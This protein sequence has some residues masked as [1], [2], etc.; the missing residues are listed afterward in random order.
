M[1]IKTDGQ[2]YQEV[3][4]LLEQHGGI[5]YDN[6]CNVQRVKVDDVCEFIDRNEKCGMS[7][8]MILHCLAL[9]FIKRNELER[10]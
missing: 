4:D 10:S 2:I 8:D 7:S 3:K 6:R 1:D 5:D 9:Q